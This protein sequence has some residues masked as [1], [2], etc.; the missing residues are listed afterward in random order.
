MVAGS[1]CG[2]SDRDEDRY[3]RMLMYLRFYTEN[4]GKGP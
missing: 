4:K 2:F 3:V 1:F